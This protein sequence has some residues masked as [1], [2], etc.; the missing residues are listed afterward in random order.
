[1]KADPIVE[2]VRANRKALAEKFNFDVRKLIT[3]ARSRQADSG[4]RLVSFILERPKAS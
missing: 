1:M 3:D 4:H 2:E